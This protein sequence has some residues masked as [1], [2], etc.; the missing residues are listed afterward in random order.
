[1]EHKQNYNIS[2]QTEKK[3][4]HEVHTTHIMAGGRILN[5]NKR[6]TCEICKNCLKVIHFSDHCTDDTDEI[7]FGVCEDCLKKALEI[8]RGSNG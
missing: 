2:W 7:I 3:G 4:S 1:M 8:A 5:Y 6:D